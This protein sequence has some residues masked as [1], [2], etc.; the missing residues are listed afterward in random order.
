[1]ET[2]TSGRAGGEEQDEGE[3]RQKERARAAPSAEHGETRPG[4]LLLFPD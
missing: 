3:D 1:M 4:S 2:E